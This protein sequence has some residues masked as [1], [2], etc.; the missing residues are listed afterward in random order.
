MVN[1]RKIRAFI[2]NT[3][4]NIPT[5]QIDLP[6]KESNNIQ[7]DGKII[8]NQY[9]AELILSEIKFQYDYFFIDIEKKIN[10]Q[11]N[12]NVKNFGNISSVSKKIIDHKKLFFYKPNDITVLTAYNLVN[13]ILLSSSKQQVTIIGAGNIGSKLALMLVE[14]GIEVV[15]YKRNFMESQ[16]VCNFINLIKSKYTIASCKT[17]DQMDLCCAYSD[18]I[19]GC[20][21][22]ENVISQ[23]ELISA[24][25]DVKL[26]DLGKNNFSNEVIQNIYS[27]NKFI[28]RVDVTNELIYNVEA[29]IKS[30][31]QFDNAKIFFDNGVISVVRGI[32][33][34]A[35][36]YVIDNAISKRIIGYVNSDR[37]FNKLL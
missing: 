27:K 12:E 5:G 37:I 26:I 2:L 30:R 3:T 19:I 34:P 18:I 31:E 25:D 28:Y 21:S 13:S 4:A 32:L 23:K 17:Y 1:N 36:S 20:S 14:S 29:M 35:N 33:A 11:L 22:A 7:I 16:N 15:I 9:Q 24:S 8:S 10:F 6:S